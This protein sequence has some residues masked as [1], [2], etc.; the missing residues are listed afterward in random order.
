MPPAALRY[1]VGESLSITNFL[2]VGKA[3]AEHLQNQLQR[4]GIGLENASRVLDFGCGSGRTLAWLI[5]QYPATQFYGADVD[6][7]AIEWCR[8]NLAGAKYV[9]NSADPPLPFEASYFDVIYCIS[10]F[11][12]LDEGKQDLWLAEMKRILKPGGALVLTVHGERTAQALD[13]DS[14][15][16]FRDRGFVHLRSRKLSGMLPE[17][18]NTSWHSRSYIVTRLKRVFGEAQYISLPDGSQDIV[19]ARAALESESLKRSATGRTSPA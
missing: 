12:H 14:A 16:L 4:I 18:Y 3:C 10:V 13:R 9:S 1:R 17:W 19:L 2:N 6:K 5:E 7:E 15:G 8:R 11:T